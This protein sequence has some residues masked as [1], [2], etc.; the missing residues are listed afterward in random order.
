MRGEH[1]Y[2]DCVY[3]QGRENVDMG[4]ITGYILLIILLLL[5]SKFI[6]KRLKSRR[7]DQISM[8]IHRPL[9]YIGI[10]IGIIHAIITLSVFKTRPLVLYIGGFLMIVVG[11]ATCISYRNRKTL[12]EKWIGLHRIAAIIMLALL[13]IHIVVYFMDFNNY[14]KAVSDIVVTD[15][16]ISSVEDGTYIGSYDVG[17]IYAKVK[18]TVGAGKITDIQLLEHNNERGK[19]AERITDTIKEKQSIS[20]DGVSGATNS[21]KVIQMAIYNALENN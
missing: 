9:A 2:R 12:G 10:I 13:V 3:L 1:H 4:I 7:L 16:D 14:Q 19:K 20:V 17:Y 15:V 6:T 5:S 8:R 18:V 21:S 11:V